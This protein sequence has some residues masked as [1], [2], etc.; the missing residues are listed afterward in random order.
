MRLRSGV[1]TVIALILASESLGDSRVRI[2]IDSAS[3]GTTAVLVTAKALDAARAPVVRTLELIEGTPAQE[4]VLPGE[5]GWSVEAEAT[6]YWHAPLAV[7]SGQEATLVLYR[8]CQV[9]GKLVV[10][11]TEVLARLETRPGG[12]SPP[13]KDLLPCAMEPNGQFRCDIPAGRWGFSLRSKGHAPRYEHTDQLKPGG[14]IPVGDLKLIP[15]ASFSGWVT[16]DRPGWNPSQAKVHLRPARALGPLATA[17][18]ASVTDLGFFQMTQVDPGVYQA[19]AG[20]PGSSRDIRI[21][22]IVAGLEASLAAPFVLGEARE[23]ALTIEPPAGPDGAPWHVEIRDALDS[24]PSFVVGEGIARGGHLRWKELRAGHRYWLWLRTG[25]GVRWLADEQGFVADAPVVEKLVRVSV[26]SVTGFV[27]MGTEPIQAWLTFGI[28]TNLQIPMVSTADGRF[29][30]FL[31]ALGR[32]RVRV[33]ASGERSVSKDLD[34]EVVRDASGQGTLEI[35]LEDMAI[36]GVLVDEKDSLFEGRAFVTIVERGKSQDRHEVQGPRFRIGGLGPGEYALH[37]DAHGVRSSPQ[38]VTLRED[39]EADQVRLVM[40]PERRI[41]VRIL[42]PG[43]MPAVRVPVLVVPGDRAHSGSGA[44]TR[45]TD[46]SG[47]M[48]YDHLG[49]DETHSCLVIRDPR[50]NLP[51]RVERVPIGPDEVTIQLDAVGG[52]IL[53]VEGSESARSPTLIH[54]GCP[55]WRKFFAIGS[56]DDFGNFSPGVYSLCPDS[57]WEAG[58]SCVSGVLAPLKTLTLDLRKTQGGAARP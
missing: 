54:N 9:S 48:V 41:A 1:W 4:V 10:G 43:G 24:G 5:S 57:T 22:E 55:V 8:T 2:G 25:S 37:A 51:S 23:L 42:G 29:T 20:Q 21:I 3:A 17:R 18:S 19:L 47:R 26:E 49:A 46:A 31:P 32:W 30:G 44:F 15:G 7:A 50:G 36:H 14:D 34:V 45:H 38:S 58:P 27:L 40:K 35:R 12:P 28:D 33:A 52:T 39:E 16:S 53:S 6:G 56:L 11:G 13:T